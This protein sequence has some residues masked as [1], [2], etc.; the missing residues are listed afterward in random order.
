MSAT[1]MPVE[2]V[3]AAPDCC[4]ATGAAS[5]TGAG[6]SNAPAAQAPA[7]ATPPPRRE[8]AASVAIGRAADVSRPARAGSAAP[9]RREERYGPE[10]SERLIPP[11][12]GRAP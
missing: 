6:S 9:G 1:W 8:A 4:A 2:P 5:T 7:S 3:V 12:I 10:V 11:V